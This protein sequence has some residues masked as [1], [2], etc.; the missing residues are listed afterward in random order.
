MLRCDLSD[1]AN[2]QFGA[3]LVQLC[4]EDLKVGFRVARLAEKSDA[5]FQIEVFALIQTECEK[6]GIGVG[7][8]EVEN[9]LASVAA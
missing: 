5:S 1:G 3:H 2:S 7:A 9:D 8:S 4:A 6:L